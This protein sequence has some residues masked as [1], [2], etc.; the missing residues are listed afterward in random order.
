M[1]DVLLLLN[2][3]ILWMFFG[4]IHSLLAIN[5]VKQYFLSRGLSSPK[6]RLFYNS[7]TILMLLLILTCTSDIIFVVFQF[8][9]VNVLNQI[10]F[11]LLL[12]TGGLIII[13]VF[14]S[15]D[16]LGFFGLSEEQIVINEHGIYA[17]A[18]HPVYTGS[19]LFLL[20][21]IAIEISAATLSWLIGVTIY[22]ILGSIPE[23]SKLTTDH[24][25]Y[26]LYKKK[27][28]RFFPANK[29]NW[30]YFFNRWKN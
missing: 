13:I 1:I 15:W 20:S 8:S 2:Y 9:S 21:F 7:I 10:A 6:Y 24:P 16:L 14:I 3:L 4:S 12:A 23:E 19:I 17:F 11:L 30:L 5:K 29:T 18:R 26:K 22:C 27:V 28:G 25:Q